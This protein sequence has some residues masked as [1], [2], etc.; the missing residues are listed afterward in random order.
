[1]N[2]H[3]LYIY[4]IMCV[5]VCVCVCVCV[6]ERER[7]RERACVCVRVYVC[8]RMS[9]WYALVASQV[10]HDKHTA[11]LPEPLGVSPPHLRG[12]GRDRGGARGGAHRHCR[13]AGSL[14]SLRP[15]AL[16]AEGRIH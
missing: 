9:V 4:S 6:R 2:T 3:P 5:Y 10:T 16:V 15:H 7:E 1:M 12:R 11:G 8:V 14:P 13:D